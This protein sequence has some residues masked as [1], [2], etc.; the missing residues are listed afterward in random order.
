MAKLKK[1]SSSRASSKCFSAKSKTLSVKTSKKLA[2]ASAASNQRISR[3]NQIYAASNSH[4][5]Y[6]ATK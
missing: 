5:S 3:N 4:A 1:L 6:Y 2:A